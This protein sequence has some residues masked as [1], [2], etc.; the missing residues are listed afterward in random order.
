MRPP[1]AHRT[2][3]A[4]LQAAYP[5][6]GPQAPLQGPLLGADMAGRP[7]CF[8]PWER[9]AAG[10]L[11][12]PNMVVIGQIGRG[13][14][15]FVKTLVWRSLAFGRRAWIIDPKGEYGPLAEAAGATTVRLVPGGD[16]RLNPL[17]VRA[18][19]DDAA[20]RGA[21][22]L[23]AVLASALG[24]SLQPPERTALDLAVG[25]AAGRTCG[26]PPVVPD[27]VAAL[28]EPDA[29]DAAAVHTDRAGLAADGRI[30]ALELR[31]LVGGDLAGM[32]D[33]PSSVHVD[34]DAPVVVLDLS[35]L[36]RSPALGILMVCAT[37]WLHSAI[38]GGR[39][40]KRLVVVDEAWAV[41]QDLA[42]AR[43]LRAG[44][45][46]ARSLGVAHVAVV[47]RCSDLHAAGTGGSE[48]RALAEG[49]L[50]D[51]ETRVAFAQPPGEAA[52]ATEALG[53]SRTEAAA[54]PHLPRGVALWKIGDRATIVRHVVSRSE[55]AL[56]DTDAAMRDVEPV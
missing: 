40:A 28:L 43:W 14:S 20:R 51:A 16:A 12:G 9:Y 25:A 39:P 32:F 47:H 6:A 56:V 35:A 34:L 11:T 3:T 33:G 38:E 52:A 45:K 22:V 5:F 36:H 30:V 17:E 8:D 49:L 4:H 50:A 26:R 19:A 27:V 2:T 46:L 23:A 31:R 21:E 55:A 41:L 13:K 15:T 24:R 44:F 53:L 29:S 10:E 48:Q 42:T 7:F 54:L 1:T 18:R 37:A